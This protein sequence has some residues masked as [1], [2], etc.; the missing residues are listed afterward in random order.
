QMIRI[1]FYGPGGPKVVRIHASR[2]LTDERGV[3]LALH[4]GA[5]LRR[6]GHNG[7]VSMAGRTLEGLHAAPLMLEQQ[8]CKRVALR[9]GMTP[10]NQRL[11]VV[12]EQE[13]RTGE[14]LQD[15]HAG[16]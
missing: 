1:G 2:D 4:N 7:V 6:D 5:I 11:D 15:V 14:R 8:A 3:I 13:R 9:L 10:P 16:K 12:L